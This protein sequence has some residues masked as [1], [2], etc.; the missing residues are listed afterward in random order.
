MAKIAK[1][2]NKAEKVQGLND[3]IA[4]LW[5]RFSAL[6]EAGHDRDADQIDDA[7]SAEIDLGDVI[8]Q[9][10]AE[11]KM[12]P[13]RIEAILER[14]RLRRP[15]DL[16]CR[17][18]ET[19]GE[20]FYDAGDGDIRI[21]EA[22]IVPITGEIGSFAGSAT[23]LVGVV[24][25]A[26]ARSGYSLIGD[27]SIVPQLYA[28]SRLTDIPHQ[29]VFSAGIK[30]RGAAGVFSPDDLPKGDSPLSPGEI[31]MRFLIGFRDR[32]SSYDE[33]PDGFTGPTGLTSSERDTLCSRDHSEKDRQAI[34]AAAAERYEALIERYD[35]EMMSLTPAGM[36][37]L[38]PVPWDKA[39]TTMLRLHLEG[40]EFLAGV[41]RNDRKSRILVSGTSKGMRIRLYTRDRKIADLLIPKRW[42]T[43]CRTDQIQ[44]LLDGYEVILDEP[45]GI[46]G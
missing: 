6:E 25:G 32:P 18:R 12:T 14:P 42:A 31:G 41:K 3:H 22:F 19:A 46:K 38:E 44:N 17:I 21:R 45:A 2:R 16:G 43:I 29:A 4:S 10:F 39:P 8:R 15:Y 40:R 34:L 5:M 23:D 27:I 36:T 9:A 35:A 30:A 37:V 26:I 24:L 28:V 33:E 13:S 7:I 20:V 11:G 1:P